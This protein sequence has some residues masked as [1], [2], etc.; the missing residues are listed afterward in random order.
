MDH[1]IVL[2]YDYSNRNRRRRRTN[3]P[4]S[5]AISMAMSVHRCNTER[6]TQC[7]GDNHYEHVPTLLAISIAIA[8]QRCYTPHIAQWRR[9]VAFIKATKRHH[10]TS[11]RS[12]SVNW[13]SQCCYFRDISSSNRWKRARVALITIGVWHINLTG[14]TWQME[15]NTYIRVLNE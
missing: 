10:R 1:M 4:S 11:T 14:R 9:F 6:I 12:D 3:A 13:S 7:Q 15:W 2:S 8:M 5:R